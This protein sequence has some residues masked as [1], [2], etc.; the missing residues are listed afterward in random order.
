MSANARQFASEEYRT[1]GTSRIG[2]AAR[3]R[4]AVISNGFP[5]R[6]DGSYTPAVI[7]LLMELGNRFDITVFSI[8]N[9]PWRRHVTAF[10]PL[11]VV[12]AGWRSR[13]QLLRAVPWW[14]W[15]IRRRHRQ[16]PFDVLHGL[17][18]VGGLWATILGKALGLPVIISMLG[19]EAVHLPDI[20]YGVAGRRHWR[21]LL[22]WCFRRARFVT[23][24]SQYYLRRLQQFEPQAVERLRLAPLGVRAD[25]TLGAGRSAETLRVMVVAA[26]QPVKNLPALL[27]VLQNQNG[28]P[29]HVSIFGE[30]PLRAALE[31]RLR[32]SSLPVQLCDWQPPEH[33]HRRYLHHDVLLSV[34]RHE[35]QGMALIE[36]AAHGLPIIAPAVG[37]VAELQR[38]GAAV[39]L[40]DGPQQVPSALKQLLAHRETLYR[41]ARTAAPAVAAHFDIRRCAGR[42]AALYLQAAWK[43]NPPRPWYAVPTPLMLRLRRRL[44]PAV[45]RLAA[46]ILFHFR[47][48]NAPTRVAGLELETRLEVFHPRFFLSSGIFAR[49]VR[50]LPLAGCRVLD[51]GTGSGIIGIIAAQRGAQ[52]LAVDVNTAAVALADRNAH[53]HGVSDHMTCCTSDLFDQLPRRH[54]FEWIFFNPPFYAQEPNTP[55]EKALYAG[56]QHAVLCRFLKQ[57]AEYLA[58]EGRL[59]LILS[60]DMP[61]QEVDAWIGEY[62]YR[63]TY[64]EGRVHY[65]EI[66]HILHLTH[67]GS[68]V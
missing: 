31:R 23:A 17:W 36:A 12:A 2:P 49:H 51:M 14:L 18:H 68:S 16:R 46:P 55:A 32:Q 66:F 57:A 26:M 15:Q 48:K 42:F 52:V 43:P 62:G 56:T 22:R 30:G 25:G 8:G 4:V 34:S 21:F 38:L 27:D 54:R 24:G 33:F 53:R 11:Q 61:L 13:W 63:V 45:F 28:V 6:P 47:K 35:A 44:R 39:L 60:S 7:D 50:T 10:G 59:V 64:H 1:P 41:Q 40:I 65:F 19:G 3:L 5:E 9:R 29:L 58:P 67:P 37:V 20:G